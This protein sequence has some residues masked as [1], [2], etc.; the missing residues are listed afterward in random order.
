M[1]LILIKND[2]YW[3][4]MSVPLILIII[5][6]SASQ[7]IQYYGEALKNLILPYWRNKESYSFKFIFII[8]IT[9]NLYG[10]YMYAMHVPSN[11]LA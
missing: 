11:I 4:L 1:R 7:L 8:L 3:I 6:V 10:R 2:F 5:L 9:L